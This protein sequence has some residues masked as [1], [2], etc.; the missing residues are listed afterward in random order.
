MSEMETRKVGEKYALKE[1]YK[2]GGI[3]GGEHGREREQQI[4]YVD[5]KL[6]LRKGESY[7]REVQLDRSK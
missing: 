6:G 3:F 5:R 7:N 4:K 2:I 1:K